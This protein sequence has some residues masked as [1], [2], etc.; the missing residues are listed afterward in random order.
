MEELAARRR[1]EQRVTGEVELRGD[2][3][4]PTAKGVRD[5]VVH[6]RVE[7][8]LDGGIG[9]LGLALPP[10]VVDIRPC[11]AQQDRLDPVSRRPPRGIPGADAQAPDRLGIALVRRRLRL[12]I[13]PS[14]GRRAGVVMQLG[15]EPDE[16]LDRRLDEDAVGLPAHLAK[17]D[18]ARRCL[19]GVRADVEDIVERL[20]RSR[21]RVFGHLPRSR[22]AGQVRQHSRRDA[23][24]QD[25]IDRA[26]ALVLD[27]GTGLV[28]PWLDHGQEVGLL[29]IG[30]GADHGHR[31]A[32]IQQVD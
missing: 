6:V 26:R 32:G 29:D 10:A 21:V 31:G 3:V 30:P 8:L 7:R 19:A 20:Q 17:L 24:R 9:P 13:V 14:G 15:V 28:L 16:P 4:G 18:E 22:E 2:R 5:H 23:G 12:E 25:V 1:G 27:L 11:L